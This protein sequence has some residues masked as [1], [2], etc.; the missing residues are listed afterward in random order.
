MECEAAENVFRCDVSSSVPGGQSDY[1]SS[2]PMAGLPLAGA[3]M[4]LC[5][6]GPVGL[7]AGVKLGGVAAV[8]GSFLGYTGACVIKEQKEMRSYIDQQY[9]AEP[10]LCIT[11]REEA[12]LTRRQNSV[13]S[14]DS[15]R[16]LPIRRAHSSSE[17]PRQLPSVRRSRLQHS[18]STANSPGGRRKLE[19][20]KHS[21]R[22]Q[23]RPIQPP[24]LRTSGQFRRLGDLSEEEQRSV[25]ALIAAHAHHSGAENRRKQFARQ[26]ERERRAASLPDVLEES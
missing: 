23:P 22:R 17:Y 9:K 7:L 5:L 11:P 18:D 15:V 16:H 13:R 26:H 2:V 10:E 6:G 25:V 1:S 19:A 4:G 12:R 21:P 8:G 24:N 20:T 14:G 3:M